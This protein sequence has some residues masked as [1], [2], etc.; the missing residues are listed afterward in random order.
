[1]PEAARSNVKQRVATYSDFD[2]IVPGLYVGAF[3]APDTLDSRFNVLVFCADEHQPDKAGYP[4]QREI[5]RVRL[6]DSELTP[7]DASSAIDAAKL[8]AHRVRAGQKVLVTCAMGVNRSAFVAAIALRILTGKPG[9]WAVEQVRA[10][11]RPR[12]S[13]LKVLSNSSFDRYLRS[14][15]GRK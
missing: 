3:P 6:S 9:W 1:M 12:V 2:Q 7:T 15:S 14:M 13:D 5:I 4:R 10:R 11:R 8:A